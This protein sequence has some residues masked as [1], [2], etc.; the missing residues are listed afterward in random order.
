MMPITTNW[1]FL[2]QIYYYLQSHA[3]VVLADHKLENIPDD[4]YYS[5]ELQKNQHRQSAS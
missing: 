2:I 5:Y 1:I 4:G 3:L